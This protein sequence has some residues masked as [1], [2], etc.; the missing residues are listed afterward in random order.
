[1]EIGQLESVGIA[2]QQGKRLIE[3]LEAVN[4]NQVKDVAQKYFR[5][6]QLTVGELDPQAL[7]KA[8]PGKVAP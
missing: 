5:D 7:P 8:R 4:A 6:E 2:Y 1:M 3:K